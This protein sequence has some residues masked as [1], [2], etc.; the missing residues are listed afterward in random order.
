MWWRG[1]CTEGWIAA[2]LAGQ[3]EFSV[4]GNWPLA[5]HSLTDQN[6]AGCGL[7]GL[8][9]YLKE[10]QNSFS[11]GL[12]GEH[13]NRP[14]LCLSKLFFGLRFPVETERSPFFYVKVVEFNELWSNFVP[15]YA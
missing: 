11:Y 14:Q 2:V 3:R 7:D 5:E 15:L 4:S 6:W 12:G 10:S 1:L 8:R 9:R 13:R